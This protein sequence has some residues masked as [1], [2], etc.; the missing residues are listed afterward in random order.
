MKELMGGAWL[1]GL[2]AAA[3]SFYV[4]AAILGVIGVLAAGASWQAER[5]AE[6]QTESW[7]KNYPTYGY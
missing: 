7:R 5:I 1:A 6:Q 2:L 4:G 3:M